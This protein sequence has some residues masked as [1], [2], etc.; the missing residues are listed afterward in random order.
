MKARREAL[1]QGLGAL[2]LALTVALAA[3]KTLSVPPLGQPLAG[4]ESPSDRLPSVRVRAYE[5]GFEPTNVIVKAGYP[6]SWKAVG[7]Q[8]HLVTPASA[9]ARWVFYRAA[10]RGTA[11]HVFDEPG[12]YKY[13]CSLHPKM[14]GTVTVR[15][16]L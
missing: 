11:R 12:V 9:G 13:Y 7:E 10:A 14:R 1:L 6:V 4:Y 8:Q 15:R 16:E 5:F 2:A 3:P